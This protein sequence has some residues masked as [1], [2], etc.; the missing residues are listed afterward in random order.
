MKKCLQFLLVLTFASIALGQDTG[1]KADGSTT[2]QPLQKVYKVNFL[3]YELED[4]KKINERAYTVPVMTQGGRPRDSSIKV[5]D[6]LPI[7][8]KEGQFQ[9]FDVGLDIDCNVTEQ[10]DKFIVSSNIEISSIVMPEQGHSDAGVSSGNPVVRQIKQR[11]ITLV[12]P[13]KP[14]VVTS[15]D[16]VNS[17]KRLQVEVTANRLE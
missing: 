11:F 6:R 16:D 2:A 13:G 12:S 9:Y 8:A 15:I 5:G 17:K 7:M 14:A 3:I 4:G 10:G 1:T